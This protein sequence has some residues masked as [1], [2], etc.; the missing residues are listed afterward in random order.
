MRLL[1]VLMLLAAIMI[2]LGWFI[3]ERFGIIGVL[4]WVLLFIATP[5]L[6]ITQLIHARRVG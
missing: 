1:P 3:P 4:G 2:A 5:A 6:A